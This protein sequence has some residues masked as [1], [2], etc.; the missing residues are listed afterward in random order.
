MAAFGPTDG[1]S[2]SASLCMN[3]ARDLSSTPGS[4]SV[5]NQPARVLGA[6]PLQAL[7]EATSTRYQ[8]GALPA[9]LHSFL[10]MSEYRIA[11]MLASVQRRVSLRTSDALR[12]TGLRL[13]AHEE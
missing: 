2:R 11:L 12:N 1:V 8:T 3:L 13:H 5:Q 9:S 7:F 6:A 4:S 10:S